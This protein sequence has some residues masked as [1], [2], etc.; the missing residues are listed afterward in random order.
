MNGEEI[1]LAEVQ[2]R[3]ALYHGPYVLQDMVAQVLLEQE[4]RR[5]N[6]TVTQAEVEAKAEA[7]RAELGVRSEA[8]LESYLRAQ[9]V[10]MDWL[11]ARAHDYALLEKV[12][13]EQTY[14]SEQEIE[15]VYRRN[16]QAY[17]QPAGVGF[18]IL[19]FR[20]EEEATSALEELRKGRRFADVAKRFPPNTGELQEYGKGQARALPPEFEAVIFAAPLNQ[21]QGPLKLLNTYHLVRVERKTDPHQFT[22]DEV[23]D[24]IREQLR[25]RKLGQVVWPQWIS[26]Q[27]TNAEIKVVATGSATSG[28]AAAASSGPTGE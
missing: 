27:L 10:T 4:A 14:V 5:R 21:V 3:S 15:A 23:R 2:R 17:R 9:R 28:G 22:L 11:R 26:A 6:I 19:S 20:T 25:R 8:A 13:A 7:V 18:R 1:S 12:F 24:V 16:P